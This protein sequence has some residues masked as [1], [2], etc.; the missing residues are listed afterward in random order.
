LKV[1]NFSKSIMEFEEP[2]WLRF[3]WLKMDENEMH[4]HGSVN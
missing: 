4:A 2:P 1:L 3:L